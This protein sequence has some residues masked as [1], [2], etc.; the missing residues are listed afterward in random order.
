MKAEC[1]VTK[2]KSGLLK[3]TVVVSGIR[4]PKRLKCGRLYEWFF[5]SQKIPISVE[6]DGLSVRPVLVMKLSRRISERDV[7]RMNRIRIEKKIG[8]VLPQEMLI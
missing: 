6:V 7:I 4:K 1:K 8:I 5:I 3:L 2:S